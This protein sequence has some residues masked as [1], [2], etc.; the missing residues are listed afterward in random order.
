MKTLYSYDIKDNNE[1]RKSQKTEK[2]I[3]RAY[4]MGK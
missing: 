3:R 4:G 2:Q 1:Y